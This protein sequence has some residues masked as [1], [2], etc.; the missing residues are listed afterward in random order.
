MSK[1]QIKQ[2]LLRKFPTNYVSTWQ[3]FGEDDNPDFG[4]RHYEPSLGIVQ[5]CYADVVDYAVELKRFFT[6]GGGG[7]IAEVKVQSIDANKTRE[8]REAQIRLKEIEKE[9]AELEAKISWLIVGG[10]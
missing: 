4:G 1:E 9:K 10:A 5:G 6:W 8:L 3:I 7:R 2:N